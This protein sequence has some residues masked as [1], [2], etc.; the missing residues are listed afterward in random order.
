M[1]DIR[2]LDG[3]DSVG[4]FVMKMNYANG[5]VAY[6]KNESLDRIK[7]YHDL[8]AKMP[9]IVEAIVYDPQGKAVLRRAYQQAA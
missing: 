3:K 9:E 5:S 4:K 8:V 1:D 6:M 7:H 2:W